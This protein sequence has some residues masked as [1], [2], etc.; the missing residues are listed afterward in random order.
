MASTLAILLHEQVVVHVSLGRDGR[1]A[2]PVR[3]FG[4]YEARQGVLVDVDQLAVNMKTITHG[5]EMA[6]YLQVSVES[7]IVALE[8]V[9]LNADFLKILASAGASINFVTSFSPAVEYLSLLQ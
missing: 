1:M 9:Q 5:H 6:E 4:D 7:K 3:P 2:L 8:G